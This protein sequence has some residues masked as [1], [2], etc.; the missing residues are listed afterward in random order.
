MKELKNKIIKVM[1]RSLSIEDFGAW[2][3]NN[4]FIRE[5]IE[6]NEMVLNLLLIDLKSKNAL[7]DLNSFCL[8]FFKKEDYYLLI[9]KNWCEKIIENPTIEN[10]IE[11]TNSFV[12]NDSDDEFILLDSFSSFSYDLAYADDLYHYT[13]QDVLS[14]FLEFSEK[15]LSELESATYSEKNKLLTDG[16]RWDLEETLG[17]KPIISKKIKSPKFKWIKLWKK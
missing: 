15:V 2:L 6:C 7:Y 1:T 9:I 13:S 17:V 5:N 8:I 3:Y 4:Q 12:N 14:N 11:I 10:A 16:L